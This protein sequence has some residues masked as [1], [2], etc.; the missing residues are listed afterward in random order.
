[1]QLWR[2]VLVTLTNFRRGINNGEV[3]GE[4][5]GYMKKHVRDEVT[6]SEK[7]ESFRWQTSPPVCRAR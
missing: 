5:V 7:R 4:F 6:G 2:R 1:M 3:F